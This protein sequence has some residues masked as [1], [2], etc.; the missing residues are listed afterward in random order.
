[1]RLRG[2]ALIAVFGFAAATTV[3]A[4][5][6]RQ[7]FQVVVHPGVQGTWISRTALSALFTG[8]SNRWGD[9]AQALP[10]DQSASAAVRRAFTASVIGQSM[11]EL[12]MYWQRRVMSDHVYPPPI[13]GSDQE[14]LDYVA[15][16]AGAVGY[17]D[18]GTTIPAGVKVIDVVD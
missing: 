9:K 16:H 4:S 1:M 2:R 6:G 8:T 5:S 10:V 12:Q 17:V 11:G 14:V 18:G 7:P 13:K 3:F 15:A